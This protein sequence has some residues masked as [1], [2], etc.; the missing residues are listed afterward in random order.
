MRNPDPA[1]MP[2]A[3]RTCD[4]C[5]LGSNPLVTDERRREILKELQASGRAFICHKAS[6]EDRYVV[7][8][9]FYEQELSLSVILARQLGATRFVAL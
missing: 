5:L 2:V 4:R 8:R 1:G 9:S 7:C 3:E 6:M